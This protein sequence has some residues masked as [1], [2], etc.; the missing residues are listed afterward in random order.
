MGIFFVNNIVASRLPWRRAS[1]AC[2]ATRQHVTTHG[3]ERRS[4]RSHDSASRSKALMMIGGFVRGS[5]RTTRHSGTGQTKT[6]FFF[7]PNNLWNTYPRIFVCL[8]DYPWQEFGCISG[9]RRP[10]SSIRRQHVVARVDNPS[11]LVDSVDHVADSSSAYDSPRRAP[12]RTSSTARIS[13]PVDDSS[14][15][16]HKKH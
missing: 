8:Y 3:D 5:T 15:F 10:A 1:T 7:Q 12:R 9:R 4:Q 16:L 13:T 11:S 14:G 2:Q 6:N